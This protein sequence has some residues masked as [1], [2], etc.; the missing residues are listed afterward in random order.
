MLFYHGIYLDLIFFPITKLINFCRHTEI[1]SYIFELT[2]EFD[3]K[4]GYV[5]S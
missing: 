5:C 4:L 3:S 2:A 1:I